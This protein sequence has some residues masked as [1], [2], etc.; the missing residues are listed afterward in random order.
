MRTIKA[1]HPVRKAFS[2]CSSGKY[3]NSKSEAIDTFNATLEEHGFHLDYA[4]CC[5]WSSDEGSVGVRVLIEADGPFDV[6]GYPRC[7]GYVHFSWY[8]MQS[9][10]WEVIG[11]LT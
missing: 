2:G 1:R 6:D 10:R 4:D 7:V 3:Y 8:R 5:N 11:Y 9:G